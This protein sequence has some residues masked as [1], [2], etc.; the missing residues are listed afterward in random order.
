MS[1]PLVPSMVLH[2]PLDGLV[3]YVKLSSNALEDQNLSLHSEI[4]DLEEI[5]LEMD[6]VTDD[7]LGVGKLLCCAYILT[8]LISRGKY[9][10]YGIDLLI[11]VLNE[12][13]LS[14]E[15]SL[16]TGFLELPAGM[17]WPLNWA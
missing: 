11:E 8:K 4:R 10:W 17:G 3:T 9:K 14:L 16:A 15:L 12:S 1:R 2:D 13:L 7:S 6:W 5:Y